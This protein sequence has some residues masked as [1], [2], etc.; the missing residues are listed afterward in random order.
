MFLR[1]FFSR[2][3]F[4]KNV[5]IY[6]IICLNL[7]C[8]PCTEHTIFVIYLSERK[9][10]K[11]HVQV[12][13]V[14]SESSVRCITTLNF[15]SFPLINKHNACFENVTFYDLKEK[16][17]SNQKKADL[18]VY[19]DFLKLEMDFWRPKMKNADLFLCGKPLTT[20]DISI[21]TSNAPQRIH[22]TRMTFPPT[23]KR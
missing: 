19:K 16:W 21:N 13:S 3:K 1:C 18:N 22:D 15:H 8:C 7:Y 14:V 17:M 4:H 23:W 12:H 9:M 20:V 5:C 6:H 2:C 10:F 11:A